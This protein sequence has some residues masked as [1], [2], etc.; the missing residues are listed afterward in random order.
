VIGAQQPARS[1][2]DR[3]ALQVAQVLLLG[4]LPIALLAMMIGST[5]GQQYA[6][7]FHGSLWEASRD[8]LAG[9]NPYPPPT[10]DGVASGDQFVYPPLPALVAIPLGLMPYP[11]AAGVLTVL[12]LIAMSAALVVLGVRDWRCHG[13]VLASILML[14]DVRL[15][16]ITPLL[17]LG[18]ALLWRLRDSSSAAVPFALVVVAKVFFWPLGIWLL[19]TRRIRAAGWAVAITIGL[20]LTSWALIGFAGLAEYPELLSVLAR[21]EQADGYSV[22]A[23]ALAAGLSESMARVVAAALGVVLLGSAW[24]EGRRGADLRSFALAIGACYALTPIVWLHYFLLL[25]VPIAIKSPR[26]SVGWLLPLAFWVVP[27]QENFGSPWRIYYGAAVTVAILVWATRDAASGRTDDARKDLDPRVR[28]K[29]ALPT[30]R[31]AG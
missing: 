21:V 9:R 4:A 12:L 17:V 24:R 27:F 8:I 2:A 7:D 26:F 23:A 3:V 16:A 15:G 6:F 28:P 22:V 20:V 14:H 1:R 19:A 30:R 31:G 13:A 5:L 11:W 18:V 10:P 29:G 25:Y